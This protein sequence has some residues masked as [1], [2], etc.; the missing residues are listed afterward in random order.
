MVR[1]WLSLCYVIA[2]PLAVIGLA[3]IVV[4]AA[5][6]LVAGSVPVFAALGGG[7]LWL[8]A[9]VTVLSGLLDNLDGALAALR[10]RAT[11]FG[12][13]ADALADR[14]AD[15][16]YLLALWLL[17]A[18]G[19]LVGVGAGLTFLQEYM[20]AR[21]AGLDVDE[22]GVVTV[23]ERPTRVIL[24]TFLLLGCAIQPEVADRIAVAGAAVAVAFSVAG[25]GQ[26]LRF[27]RQALR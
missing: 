12:A 21:A 8:A 26:L 14:L 11:G 4:T 18:P 5:A 15:T 24:V 23:W 17:G 6:L 19:W 13:V 9:V 27:L 25:I 10:E 7:W 2:R 22:V 20:R 3:P 1:G 16:A